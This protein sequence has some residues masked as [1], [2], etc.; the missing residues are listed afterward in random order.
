MSKNDARKGIKTKEGLKMANRKF[1][2]DEDEAD[3]NKD[4]EVSSYER[5]R[6]EAVQKSIMDKELAN[7]GYLEDDANPSIR[8]TRLSDIKE[9]QKDFDV[10]KGLREWIIDGKSY[11][12]FRMSELH[13]MNERIAELRANI[14]QADPYYKSRLEQ[15]YADEL[16]DIP[17]KEIIKTLGKETEDN[18]N[19]NKK[20]LYGGGYMEDSGLMGCDCGEPMCSSCCMTGMTAGY[21]EVSGNPI[22][23]GSTAENVRDDIPAA[24][25]TGEYVLP[26]DVVRWHG[27][28]HIQSM[29]NEAKMGLMSMHMEG[30]IHDV[31]EEEEPDS[32]K[33][34]DSGKSK[35]E[36]SSAKKGEEHSE[37]EIET[38]EGNVI[39]MVES[40]VEEIKPSGHAIAI[41]QKPRVKVYKP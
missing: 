35:D 14:K 1:Q 12:D 26:A 34:T 18:P 24:L 39:E 7:G 28:Q 27:L 36:D 16:V 5:E 2:L 32:E 30:Q 13:M 6:G 23:I 37:E 19:V 40:I 33:P 11:A 21:D 15:N 20:E 9:S 38:P 22:P 8:G 4:G 41:K 10:D 25:S 3:L 29:M 31:T 17:L